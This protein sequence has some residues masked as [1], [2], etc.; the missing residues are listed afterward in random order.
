MATVV[1]AFEYLGSL[2]IRIRK[3]SLQLELEEKKKRVLFLDLP[4][5][6]GKSAKQ[7]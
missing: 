1:G 7:G 4:A 3:C 6:S 2:L 5:P